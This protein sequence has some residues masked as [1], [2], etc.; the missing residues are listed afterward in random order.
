MCGS[1]DARFNVRRKMFVVG[2]KISLLNG[3]KVKVVKLLGQGGQGA[4]YDVEENGRHYALKWYL[5][6]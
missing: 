6:E 2:E 5:P 1:G 3:R 4:V